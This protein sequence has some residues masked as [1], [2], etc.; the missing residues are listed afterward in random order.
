MS[1]A[2]LTLQ[3]QIG[4]FLRRSLGPQ[5]CNYSL[6]GP[7]HIQIAEPWSKKTSWSLNQKVKRK[8]MPEPVSLA[9]GRRK[10]E[11]VF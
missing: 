6:A 11:H 10:L 9:P 7:L 5:H 8:S 3:W 2:T 4:E 1:I